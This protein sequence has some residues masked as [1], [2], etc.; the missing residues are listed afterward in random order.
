[1]SR[2][3]VALDEPAL[4]GDARHAHVLLEPAP[5]RPQQRIERKSNRFRRGRI[6]PG[7]ARW[8]RGREV[9]GGR[10]DGDGGDGEGTAAGK[11]VRAWSRQDLTTAR[12]GR[13]RDV[14]AR[15]A[16]LV[17]ARFT[18]FITAGDER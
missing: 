7:A 1:M 18:T 15:R 14:E 5:E 12:I 4:G 9:R 10:G 11:W 6:K 17:S 16:V 13:V 3:A 8:Q 2:A